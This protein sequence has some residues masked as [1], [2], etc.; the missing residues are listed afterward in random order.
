ML[1]NVPSPQCRNGGFVSET[2]P[3]MSFVI[4]KTLPLFV[5]KD[6]LLCLHSS[7]SRQQQLLLASFE[8]PVAFC[9]SLA[10][11]QRGGYPGTGSREEGSSPLLAVVESGPLHLG[12]TF[13]SPATVSKR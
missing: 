11:P 9:A 6:G 7:F 4:N 2:G 12:L 8:V 5:K 13:S 3:G 10:R 1:A